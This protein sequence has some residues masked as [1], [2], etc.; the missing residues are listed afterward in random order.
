MLNKSLTF[1]FGRKNK[2][3]YHLYSYC[4]WVSDI[5]IKCSLHLTVC[6]SNIAKKTYS[7]LNTK[8]GLIYHL[9]RIPLRQ[10]DWLIN[11]NTVTWTQPNDNKPLLNGIKF[12][13]LSALKGVWWS[14]MPTYG[15]EFLSKT[16]TVI[17]FHYNFHCLFF[18]LKSDKYK[19]LDLH[20]LKLIPFNF[21]VLSNF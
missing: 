20:R 2:K 13:G 10:K 15:E 9:G 16:V 7:R 19:L 11:I 4:Y 1:L 3:K 8:I 5:V 12:Y 21:L 6:R 17:E 18:V 14:V